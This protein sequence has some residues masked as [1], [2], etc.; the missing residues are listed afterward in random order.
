MTLSDRFDEPFDTRKEIA[1]TNLAAPEERRA[2]WQGILDESG[3]GA[4]A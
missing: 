1:D 3:Q 4:K 2:E